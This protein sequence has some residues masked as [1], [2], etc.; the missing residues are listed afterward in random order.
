M[1]Y[2]KNCRSFSKNLDRQLLVGVPEAATLPAIEVNKKLR[3]DDL[4]YLRSS[5]KSHGISGKFP[6]SLAPVDITGWKFNELEDTL[7]TADSAIKTALDIIA[8]GGSVDNMVIV[9]Y[10]EDKRWGGMYPHEYVQKYMRTKVHMMLTASQILPKA[11][12]YF[13]P[14]TEIFNGL[15]REYLSHP[16]L[17]NLM[18]TANL[19]NLMM[20]ANLKNLENK[21]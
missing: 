17:Y 9:C 11:I 19:Y 4:M 10:R 1:L 13:K 15:T 5:A 20:T 14:S 7:T 8:G 21:S 3:K 16:K 18:M 6:Y 12:E 2:V